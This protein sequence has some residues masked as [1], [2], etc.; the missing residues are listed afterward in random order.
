MA[1]PYVESVLPKR[2][3]ER[4]LRPDPKWQK[5]RIDKLD[6]SLAAPYILQLDPNLIKL[7]ND[8]VEPR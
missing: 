5:S 3:A 8:T 2:A 7:R 6:P 1:K 4:R